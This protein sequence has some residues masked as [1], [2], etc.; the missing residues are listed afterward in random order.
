MEK[1]SL[2]QGY[3]L[4]HASFTKDKFLFTLSAVSSS[5]RY[6]RMPAAIN[7][8]SNNAIIFYIIR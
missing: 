4:W 7:Y 2:K 3:L 6:A 1:L 8:H 5:S